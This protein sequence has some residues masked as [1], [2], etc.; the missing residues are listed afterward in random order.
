MTVLKKQVRLFQFENYSQNIVR[1]LIYRLQLSRN[2]LMTPS[3]E[4]AEQ[5]QMFRISIS[6][7]W[8]SIANAKKL[9]NVYF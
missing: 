4:D 1:N 2:L 9:Y 6:V 7:S 3:I 8:I 5:K